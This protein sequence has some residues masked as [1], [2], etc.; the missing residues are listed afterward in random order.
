MTR[1]LP[2]FV[3]ALLV[4]SA[5]FAQTTTYQ[6]TNPV[7]GVYITPFRAFSIPLTNGARVMCLVVGRNSA[8]YGQTSPAVGLIFLTLGGTAMACAPL[9]GSP[10]SNVGTFQGVDANGKPFSGGYSFVITTQYRC[11]GGR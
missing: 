5:A 6:V 2:L 8:S 7:S 10:T 11:S 9:M 4:S 1:A 3:L